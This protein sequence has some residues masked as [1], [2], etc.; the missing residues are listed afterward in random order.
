[1]D[2]LIK[3]IMKLEEK[4]LRQ[5]CQNRGEEYERETHRLSTKEALEKRDAR[6]LVSYKMHL[7]YRLNVLIKQW[8]ELDK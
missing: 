1:M 8:E 6:Y 7:E 3:E 4:V 5:R 2:K